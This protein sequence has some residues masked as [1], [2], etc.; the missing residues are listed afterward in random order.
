MI[1]RI[2]ACALAMPAASS[3]AHA[4]AGFY[5]PAAPTSAGQDEFHASD[6]TSCRTTMDGTKRLE[7]GSYGTGGDNLAASS[8]VYSYPYGT[9]L[10][11]R[12][13]PQKNGGVYARF[14]MSLD[15]S[16]SR[17]DCSKLY[18]LELERRRLEI[19]IMKRNLVSSDQ[20]LDELKRREPAR[21]APPTPRGAKTSSGLRG[22]FPPL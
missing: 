5:L 22:S 10:G 18:E 13:P 9:G 16:K 20:K 3:V 1:G 14:T 21:E 12:Q 6:G 19:E 8:Y 15:A 4:Q 11:G 7:V 2:L 17:M